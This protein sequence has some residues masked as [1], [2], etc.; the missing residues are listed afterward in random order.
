MRWLGTLGGSY[1]TAYSVSDNGIVVGQ[2]S[3][4]LGGLRAF[5]WTYTAGM[6]SLGTLGGSRSSA[7]GVSHDGSVVVGS[8]E[9]ASGQPRP[10]RWTAS[11]GM[12]D[13]GNVYASLLTSGS[14]LQAV[15]AVSPNGRYIVGYGFNSATSRGEGFVIDTW[16]T[17]DTNGDGSV[18]DSDLLTVLFAFGSDNAHSED[19]NKDGI[20]DD[21]DLLMVLFNFGSG[22]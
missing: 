5:R 8:A 12:Q 16:L 3:D 1:S 4:N 20:V 9:N 21:A 17:G 11:Q 13:L 6:E 10:F 19:I 22:S 2:A 7:I 18:D 14:Y 15:S